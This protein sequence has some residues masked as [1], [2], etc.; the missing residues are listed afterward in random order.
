MTMKEGGEAG[1]GRGTA[2]AGGGGRIWG[3]IVEKKCFLTSLERNDH[4]LISVS[5]V[6]VLHVCV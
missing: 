1:E 6:I 5:A 3:R 2:R 4:C